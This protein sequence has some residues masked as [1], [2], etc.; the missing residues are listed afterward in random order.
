[1]PVSF[2]NPMRLRV[3]FLMSLAIIPVEMAPVLN[4][5]SMLWWLAAG[6]CAVLLYR[7]LTGLALSVGAGARLGSITGVLTF[8]S[9]AVVFSISVAMGGK[10][11]F[12]QMDQVAKQV[13]RQNPDA[14]QLVQDPLTIFF[15]LLIVLA[16]MGAAVIGVCAAGGA[17]GARFAARKANG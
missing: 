4:S 1:M 5:S 10:E 7:K 13:A 11:F 9:M 8:V 14:A 6:W 17:L 12:D 16:I 3:S 2:S 15:M